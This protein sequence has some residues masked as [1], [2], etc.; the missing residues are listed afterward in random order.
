MRFGA[1]FASFLLLLLSG[2]AFGG[3][4]VGFNVKWYSTPAF[5]F[6]DENYPVTGGIVIADFNRDGIPDV[7]Y[8]APCCEGGGSGPVIVKMGTGGGNLGPDVSYQFGAN[9]LS[10]LTSADLNGDGWLDIVARDPLMDGMSVLLNNGD[11]TFQYIGFIGYIGG[12]PGS[13]TLGD[14]NHD[15]KI[16]L[17]EIVCDSPD[18]GFPFGFANCTLGVLLGDGTGTNFTQSQSIQLAG[19]SYNLQSADING[20]GILDL[21]YVQNNR[22]VIR[23]GLGNGTFSPQ[24]YLTP[25]TTDP[26]DAAAIADFNNDS[27]LDVALLSGHPCHPTCGAG[28]ANTVWMYQNNGGNSFTLTTQTKFAAHGGAIVAADLNGDLNQD[29]I[30]FN[31][32]ATGMYP[33]LQRSEGFQYALGLGKDDLGTQ[34][35]LAN[36]GSET[37]VAFRDMD[38]DSRPDY[39]VVNWDNSALGIGIQTGGYKICPPPSSA[40]LA[41]KICGVSDGATV[42]SPLLIKA[43]GNSPAGV[44]QMQVWIDG[45]KQYVIWD[46]Q[47]SRK[48]ALSSGMHRIGI[49]ANDKYMGSAKTVVNVIVP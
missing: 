23:F 12:L 19:A 13:F 38:G 40:N 8:S 39:A 1:W 14:F 11:G 42:T 36:N 16:D 34:G 20:D 15:G 35:T 24:I 43:S 31:P 5:P 29:L 46:D 6:V 7:A 33:V 21:I 3:G 27:R 28:T 10:E 37:A 4:T 49:I 18:A 45:K 22:G 41:A 44:N 30:Y 26:V 32:F 48:F 47:I 9:D 25:P 2:S 17:A